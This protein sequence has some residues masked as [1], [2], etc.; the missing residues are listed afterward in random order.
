MIESTGAGGGRPRRPEAPK[1]WPRSVP[2]QRT[3][4]FVGVEMLNGPVQVASG[5]DGLTLRFDDAGIAITGREQ[6]QRHVMPWSEVQ[7]VTVGDSTRE[8]SGRA[9]TPMA[10]ES[11]GATVRLVLDLDRE[12]SVRMEA[13][14]RCLRWWAPA[15]TPR[16]SRALPGRAPSPGAMRP[17]D[18]SLGAAPVRRRRLALLLAGLVLIGTGVGLA[19]SLG[20]H[21]REEPSA[22]NATAP[23]LT[24]DQRLAQ[25]VMLTRNDL[26]VG[27]RVQP[28]PAQADNSAAAAHGQ[29]QITAA[30]AACMGVS[31]QKALVVLGGQAPDQTAQ[32]SSPIFMA[33]PTG[34]DA[35][36]SLELQTAASVVRTHQDE[37][38]DLAL[39]SNP[40]Y[41][42]CAADAT[43]SELQLGVDD[44]SGTHH[45]PDTAFGTPFSVAAPVG[46]HVTAL[47]VDCE[48]ID[49][50][51]AVPVEVDEIFV[52]SDRIEADL[53]ASAIGGTIPQSVVHPSVVAFEQRIATGGSGIQI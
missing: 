4:E 3:F 7:H 43:A 29:A 11:N 17:V 52:G 27:W 12:G 21:G 8:P 28:G 23:G 2:E 40:R 6:G 44:L 46:V 20:A 41:P 34:S 33:P 13:L 5:H 1:P 32:S 42:G 15:A 9:S 39:F 48:V 26:P 18:S 37:Q 49:H 50:A 25:R 31:Q 45:R 47:R 38:D 36:Y 24:P 51:S 35:G 53:E 22:L 14:E 19:V 16:R 10:I 30:F